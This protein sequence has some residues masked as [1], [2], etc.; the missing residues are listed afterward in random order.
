MQYVSFRWCG[1]T[2]GM[3][4][5]KLM[6]RRESVEQAAREE[7]GG[8]RIW[9]VWLIRLHQECTT[10]PE[11]L[12]SYLW[13]RASGVGGGQL[14]NSSTSPWHNSG[15]TSCHL[16]RAGTLL[17]H[18]RAD[19]DPK[20]FSEYRSSLIW[21]MNDRF[22]SSSGSLV[23]PLGRFLESERRNFGVL[24][25]HGTMSHGYGSMSCARAAHGTVPTLCRLGKIP[26][27]ICMLGAAGCWGEGRRESI[28]MLQVPKPSL[29]TFKTSESLSSDVITD[30]DAGCI[31]PLV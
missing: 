21:G 25:Q 2:L 20:R 17:P 14:L 23:P 10:T 16:F 27:A 1:H 28:S 19:Q 13:H 24:A 31:S 4:V 22:C 5:K 6:W 30:H 7:F 29:K 15:S 8:Y 11:R 3:A 9:R 26:T 18:I 12:Q